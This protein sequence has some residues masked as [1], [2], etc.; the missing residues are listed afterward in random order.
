M[1]TYPMPQPKKRHRLR[2]WLIGIGAAIVAL[3]GGIVGCAAIVGTA[4]NQAA[5]PNSVPSRNSAQAGT[6]GTAPA[7]PADTPA[8]SG[9]VVLQLG[10]SA[11]ISQDG[12]DA[13]TIVLDKRVIAS[14][15]VDQYSDG[16][17]NGY[18]VAIHITATGVPGLTSGFDIN[19]LDFYA[20]SGSTHY[21][22]GDGNA[23][24]GP[25]NGSELAATTL[26]AGEIAS[27]WLLFDLPSPHGKIVYAPNFNG[28]PLAYWK[29]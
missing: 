24:E 6:S 16:P 27:G 23:F 20:L 12:T 17:Q 21:D 13:A 22:E 19:P 1:T 5:N 18:F 7:S 25:H 29:F 3:S 15:P 28:Q 4:L 9:P 11:S 2:N 8:P 26:N 10:D 14:G